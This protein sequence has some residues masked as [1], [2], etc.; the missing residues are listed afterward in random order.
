LARGTKTEVRC[1]KDAH[2]KRMEK[3]ANGGEGR[4]KLG[5]ASFPFRKIVGDNLLTDSRE[6]GGTAPAGGVGGGLLLV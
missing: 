5:K 2:W 4:F 3:A 1:Q 6:V